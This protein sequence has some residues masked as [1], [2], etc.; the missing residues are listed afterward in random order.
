MVSALEPILD[1]D[2]RMAPE[3]GA[4]KLLQSQVIL[5][6]L[7][8]SATH[9]FLGPLLSPEEAQ[10]AHSFFPCAKDQSILT[11]RD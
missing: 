1:G 9:T 7:L 10:K 4:T 2:R 6:F 3:L 11:S 5:P 8:G